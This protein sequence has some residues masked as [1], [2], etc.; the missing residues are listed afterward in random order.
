MKEHLARLLTLI[1]GA[2]FPPPGAG[3]IALAYAYGALCHSLFA[4]AVL[5]MITSV[6]F[7]MTLSLGT[8]PTPYSWAVNA[9]LLV[10]FPLVHSVLLSSKGGWLL[11]YLAPSRHA[12]RLS[13]TTYAIVASIQ[14]L[15][16]FVLWT[17]S[18][19]IWWQA[20]GAAFATMLILSGA[21]WLLLFKSVFDAGVEVQSGALGWMSLAGNVKPVFPDMPTG[22]LFRIIRQPIYV[23]FA[24]ALW[25]VSVW[26]PDQL[27]VAVTLSTYCLAAPLLKERRFKARYGA[28]FDSYRAAVPYAVPRL[29]KDKD[30]GKYAPE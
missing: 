11:R 24:L 13:T 27:V 21:A 26:T 23:A 14:L 18:G 19:T 17:P 15:A 7:G 2:V 9:M 28:R 25:P 20:Q 6:F 4:A 1:K 5:S 16:L 29:N 8:V 22:G 10:Q 3:R 12:G 30:N